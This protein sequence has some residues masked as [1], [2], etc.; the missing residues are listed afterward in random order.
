MTTDGICPE[1]IAGK[2]ENCDGRALNTRV[3][4]IGA[5]RCWLLA[6]VDREA[7]SDRV[8]TDSD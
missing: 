6:H 5:C 7:L 8:V 3:D 2:H 1:C 4:A